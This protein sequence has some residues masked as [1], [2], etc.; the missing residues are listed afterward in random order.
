MRS[1]NLS[2]KSSG[3]MKLCANIVECFFPP[4]NGVFFPFDRLDSH[5]VALGL[6]ARQCAN[7]ALRACGCVYLESGKRAHDRPKR[8]ES[9]GG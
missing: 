4:E 1:A 5:I 9:E 7:V 8:A 6:F 2:G 3:K